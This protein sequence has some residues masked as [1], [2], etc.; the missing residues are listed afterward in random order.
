MYPILKKEIT[1]YLSSLVAYVTISVF[2]LVLG[3]FLWVFP[4]TS[5]LAYGYAGLDSLFSTAPYLFMFLIPAI[6]MRSLAEERR[7][8]TFEILLTRPL[9]NLQIVLGKYFAGVVIVL[10]ALVPTLVYYFSVYTLGTPQGNIDTGAVI[11]SYIGL[12]LLGAAFTAIG[13]FASSVSKNQVIS[14]TIAVFLCFFFY[15]GFDSLNTILSLQNMGLSGL[16]ITEH[17]QSVSRGVLDTRDLVYFIVLSMLFIWLTLFVI[18]SQLKKKFNK[19]FLS[20]LGLMFVLIL[21]SVNFFTRFDFTKEKRFT[22]SPISRKMVDSLQ[23]T[24]NVTV[25]L[26]GDNFPGGMK[27]LQTSVKDMLIDLQA[28]SHNKLQYTFIDPLKGLSEEQQKQAFEE[29]DAKG[30]Q[31]QNLSVKTDDGISQKVIFPFALVSYGEK[32]IPVKL[33]ESQSSVNVTPDEVLNNSIQNLEY[34]FT[35]AI[36][37][38]TSGGKQRVGF[39]EGHGE[40]SD[41]QLN[42]AMRSLSD[43]FLVGRIDLK[44]IAFDSL[45][46]VSLLVIPKPDKP[47]TE[48]EKFKVDQYIMR[49]GRVLWAIDQ[50]TAELDSMHNHGNE[51]LAFNK[52][53]NLDDQLFGYGVRINYDL[54]ADINAMQIPVTTGDVGGQPQIQMLPWLFYPIYVPLSRHPI[55]KNLDGISSQFASTIDVLDVKNVQKTV[56]L[57]SSPFNKKISTPHMLSLQALEQEPNPKEFQSQPK[58]TAVLLEGKFVSDFRNRPVPDGLNEQVAIMPESKPTKMIVLSD[59]DMLKNQISSDGSPFP[60]GYDH[61]TQQSY[62]NK[63]LLLNITDYMTDDSGLISLRSKEI[64]IRLLSRARIRNEKLFWQ[65]INNIVPI[66]AVLIFAI[67]QHYMRKRKYAH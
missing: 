37:K 64:K 46:K 11:G 4:D 27:R 14:F 43:G 8:G 30:I 41:L 48:L 1:T 57:T 61:Y 33:L 63:N 51:Q 40:L 32:S 54:I 58:T 7:E 62:A 59:G 55:V 50:V 31:A 13:L 2:L 21:L 9:T 49:G 16:G 47:F 18:Q 67:F 26:Q 36:K 42:D 19:A 10:F 39:T 44:T 45:R 17:Y 25:Y 20:L 56:L 35:S 6:T 28:Y 65:L 22:I 34:A 52:Q 5:I 23:Q 24:I 3:L 53:L 29:L 60:L 12:F 38:I 15:S 66:G